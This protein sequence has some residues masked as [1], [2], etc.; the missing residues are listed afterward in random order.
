M[1]ASTVC[2]RRIGLI[3][4][5]VLAGG[6]L[7]ALAGR[8][9]SAEVP[10]GPAPVSLWDTVAP[11]RGQADLAQR[12]GWQVVRPAAASHLRG[13]LVV[14]AKTT[15]AAFASR[16][17]KVLVYSKADPSQRR[18]EIA[19]T[20]LSGGM[21]AIAA[22][23][24]TEEG[25]AATV[26]AEFRAGKGK[27]LPVAFSFT[28]RGILQIAP[29]GERRGIVLSAP[30]EVAVAPSFVG[31]DLLYQARDYP[32]AKSLALVSEHWL[33]GLLKGEGSMLV[34]TWQEDIPSVSAAVSQAGTGKASIGALSFAGGKGL[35]LGVL[36]APGIWHRES[37]NA[38]RF[39]ERDTTVSWRP[40]FPAMWLTQLYEDG[41]KTTFEFRNERENTWRGA[42]GN[43]I[44]PTWFSDGK[45]VL[46]LGKK[47]PAEGEAIM[48]F[49]ERT[50]ETP[51]RVLSATDIVKQ[52]LAGDVLA[53]L[54]DV[55][56]RPTWYP[57]REPYVL[58][59]ATCGVTDKM[60]E[61][62]DAGQEVEKQELIKGGVEDM[63]AYLE[64]MFERDARFYPFAQDMMGYLDAQ[65]KANAK[66]VPFL[67]EMRSTAEQIART[68]DGARDTI[69][70]MDHA[71][72]LGAQTIALAAEK[73]PD[74]PQRFVELKQAWTS[75]GGALEGLARREHTLTRELYQ[76]AGYGV[77]T[78]PE[79]MSVV[80]EVRKRTRACLER[81]ESYEIWANY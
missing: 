3:I 7:A 69:R 26:R 58:G 34:M 22:A 78:R 6:G 16:L 50:E 76:Q 55:A 20:G 57:H 25:Q 66:L 51:E 24:V 61:F 42:V 13:D 49:L 17:G 43:Y 27:A 59:G 80:R 32:S 11:L 35:F 54:L 4:L 31:D 9:S 19:P 75:M 40:P 71:R 46:S 48:Y 77:A 21:V 53:H 23:K 39:L 56:G 18:A 47:I 65:A 10:R 8:Q 15:G 2:S 36:E 14:E 64:G 72:D 28:S 74:N 38:S 73:R 12:K 68:Y 79:A 70:D 33:L 29:E 81:P 5:V 45:T 67:S 41:V 30:I 37:L 60:K 44:Y 52:T 62:F 1:M 63:Y